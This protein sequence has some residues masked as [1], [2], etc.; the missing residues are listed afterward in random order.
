MNRQNRIEDF[1]IP[2]TGEKKIVPSLHPDSY[3]G[4]NPTTRVSLFIFNVMCTVSTKF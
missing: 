4:G 3:F 2:N 1:L